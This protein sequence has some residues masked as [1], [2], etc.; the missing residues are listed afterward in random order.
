MCPVK[1]QGYIQGAH[2]NSSI[3]PSELA[4]ALLAGAALLFICTLCRT[5]SLYSVARA[6]HQFK[7][8]FF[9]SLLSQIDFRS[10]GAEDVIKL[11]D[12]IKGKGFLRS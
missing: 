5:R 9:V 3:P 11:S 1:F 4:R 12:T 6:K 2:L 8:H 7:S 10:V